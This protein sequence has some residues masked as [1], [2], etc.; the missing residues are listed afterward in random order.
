V[1]G[2]SLSRAMD[3]NDPAEDTSG[4][5]RTPNHSTAPILIIDTY[6][7]EEE[8]RVSV[9]LLKSL[10]VYDQLPE[11]SKNLVYDTLLSF[12]H[13]YFSLVEFGASDTQAAVA[14]AR[15][16][17]RGLPAVDGFPNHQSK[18]WTTPRTSA[19]TCP[20]LP[21]P[22]HAAHPNP[23]LLFISCPSHRVPLRTPVG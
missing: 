2:G 18:K 19:Q 11:S 7:A 14:C 22:P 6:T 17:R 13:A 10:R 4:S 9:A 20:T 23:T 3:H 16:W 8:R 15:G 12:R 5:T 1:E 21:S